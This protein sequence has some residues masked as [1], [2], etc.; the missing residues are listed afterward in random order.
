[1]LP[2]SSIGEKLNDIIRYAFA[3]FAIFC[4]LLMDVI[5]L[6]EPLDIFRLVPFLV[7][8]IY[9]WS[10]HRPTI[11]P[12]VLVFILGVLVDIISG[13]PIGL[14]AVIFVL[15]QW[16]IASQRAFLSAQSFMILWLVFT[17]INAGILLV[18][19][20]I[21]G[22]VQFDWT[23]LSHV[24]TQAIAGMIAYPFV[25]GVLYFAHKMLPSMNFPLTSR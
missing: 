7:I 16:A 8:A 20:F 11:A 2:F 9:F 23:S 6:P 24:L 14:N 1:M 18:Q 12:P 22:L 10:I 13:T 21:L 15:L 17:T 5:A 25:I 3:Y 4:L 19:W